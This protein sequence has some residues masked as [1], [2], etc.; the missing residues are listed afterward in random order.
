MKEL[1][2]PL[3]LALWLFLGYVYYEQ[4]QTC[5]NANATGNE[6][7]K[8]VVDKKKESKNIATTPITGTA[9]SDN[10]NGLL[11]FDWNKAQP[12]VGAQWEQYKSDLLKGMSADHILEVVGLY[13]SDE[14]NNSSFDNLGLARAHQ[15]RKLLAELPNEKLRLLGKLVEQKE[16]NTP[17]EAVQFAKRIE[18]QKISET[19]D[20][21]R[22]HFPYNSTNKLNDEAIELYLDK[23]ASEIK[24]N[25]Y[26]V[27][28]IGHA[29][30]TGEEGSNR[31][32]GMWRAEVIRNFLVS[33]GVSAH[34]ISV[35]TMGES[36]PIASNDTPAGRAKNRRTELKIIK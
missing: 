1:V 20:G 5:C 22:I 30:S 17:H 10:R 33:R 31:R 8:A 27:Q 26:K 9:A 11:Y 13:G 18:T 14:K 35:Q 21:A 34:D 19:A 29:D 6:T 7:S 4:S 36:Q 12:E 15:V 32:L 25:G 24:Q 3:I 2:N 16:G 28:L 23:I